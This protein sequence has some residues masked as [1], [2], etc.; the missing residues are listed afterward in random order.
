M[1]FILLGI[2]YR[3]TTIAIGQ[4]LVSLI[5]DILKNHNRIKQFWKHFTQ[6]YIEG[7]KK[8]NPSCFGFPDVSSDLDKDTVT[9]SDM[10][11]D[12]DMD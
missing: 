9:S 3:L 8:R 5:I 6:N 10:D 2:V 4:G 11:S 12:S 1:N 7:C